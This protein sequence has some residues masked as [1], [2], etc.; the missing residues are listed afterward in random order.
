[1]MYSSYPF[2]IYSKAYVAGGRA[3]LAR[4][5]D[6]ERELSKPEVLRPHP[7]YY[8][9]YEWMRARIHTT[10]RDPVPDSVVEKLLS[11]DSDELDLLLKHPQAVQDLSTE[12]VG[13]LESGGEE[14]LTAHAIPEL[15]WE[16]VQELEGTDVV[17]LGL[18]NEPTRVGV[19]QESSNTTP[20]L[21]EG[22]G[23]FK[24]LEEDL[25]ALEELEV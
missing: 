19:G 22:D 13:L 9:Y 7:K 10:L 15:T 25:A 16:N 20:T 23:T 5:L 21:T 3:G 8:Y 2:I 24:M 6:T 4:W 14:A 12:L 18:L 1:M 17:G 11:I